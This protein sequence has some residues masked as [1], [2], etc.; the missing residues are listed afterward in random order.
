MLLLLLLLLLK[1]ISLSRFLLS[2]SSL[3][4]RWHSF[5]TLGC[6]SH[7]KKQSFNYRWSLYVTQ[8]VTVITASISQHRFTKLSSFKVANI[9]WYTEHV[10]FTVITPIKHWAHLYPAL[11][12]YLTACSFLLFGRSI[13]GAFPFSSS[14]STAMNSHAPQIYFTAV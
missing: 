4:D 9:C 7:N 5:S 8:T 11:N 14:F 10:L 2:L 12:I 3:P 13:H 6:N 1:H